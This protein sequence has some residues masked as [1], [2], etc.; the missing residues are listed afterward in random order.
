M[1]PTYNLKAVTNNYEKHE[2]RFR[3]T[4]LLKRVDELEA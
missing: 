3:D 1:L 4:R 2:G